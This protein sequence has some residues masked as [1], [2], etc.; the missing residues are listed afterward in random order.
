MILLQGGNLGGAGLQPSGDPSG[1][2]GRRRG[3]PP[4]PPDG[5]RARPRG[6]DPRSDFGNVLV[7]DLPTGTLESVMDLTLFGGRTRRRTP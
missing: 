3:E 2:G 1:P 6:T 5:G 4:Y 7:V